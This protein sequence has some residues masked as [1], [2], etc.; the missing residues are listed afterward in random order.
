VWSALQYGLSSDPERY[1]N[2]YTSYRRVF[3]PDGNSYFLGGRY[4]SFIITGGFPGASGIG[5]WHWVRIEPAASN[6]MIYAVTAN[7]LTYSGAQLNLQTVNPVI[8]QTT[9]TW[10]NGP[11]FVSL[12]VQSVP[13]RSDLMR[14]CWNAYLPPPDPVTGPPDYTPLVRTAPFKRLQCGIY[15]RAQPSPDRGAYMIDDYDGRVVTYTGAW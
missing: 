2:P 5:I 11:Y 6:G 14:V 9:A 3:S 1:D 12:L 10:T 13:G 4:E 15:D 7:G 8:D